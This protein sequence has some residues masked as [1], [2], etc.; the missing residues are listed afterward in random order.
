MLLSFITAII[1]AFTTIITAI[2]A[3]VCGGGCFENYNGH[4]YF[5]NGT[6]GFI[7]SLTLL[8]L[9]IIVFVI[10]WKASPNPKVENTHVMG[11]KD[12]V[13]DRFQNRYRSGLRG[14]D[15]TEGLYDNL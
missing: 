12:K 1:F 6:N 8:I 5:Y 11:S 14:K 9:S 13:E 15:L 10:A 2:D 4:D 3:L 7:L